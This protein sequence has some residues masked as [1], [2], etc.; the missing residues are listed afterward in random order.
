[1]VTQTLYCFIFTIAKAEMHKAAKV[2]KYRAK[3]WDWKLINGRAN[4]VIRVC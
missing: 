2:N 1:M 3:F 4:K